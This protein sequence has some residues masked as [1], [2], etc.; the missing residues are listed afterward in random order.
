MKAM[1]RRPAAICVLVAISV[2]SCLLGMGGCPRPT[3]QPTGNYVGDA[4]CAQCHQNIHTNW[5]ATLHAHAIEALESVGQENNPGCQP[6]HTTG[7]GQPGG[8]VDLAS[9][10]Q[11]VGVQCEDCHGPAGQHVANVEDV[12][13]R[14]VVSIAGDVCGNCHGIDTYPQFLQWRQS[15]H[16]V[17]TDVPAEDFAAGQLLSI[18]GPCHSGDYRFEAF[19]EGNKNVPPT[20]LQ[21]VP[22]DQQNAV[23]CVICHDP[24]AR[25]GNAVNPDDDRDF[26]LRYP[27]AASPDPTNVIAVITNPSQYNLCGQ[28]HHSRGDTWKATERSPHHSLQ[29]NMYIGDMPMPV[30]QEGTPLVENTR[31]VHRFVPAQCATCHMFREPSVSEFAPPI[32]GH[33]FVVNLDACS[34]ATGC[35][36]SPAGADAD[37]AALQSE[38][39]SRLDNIAA[40]LGPISTW[41]YSAE[42]GPPASA[43]AGIPDTIKQVRFLYFYVLN[44]G[45]LGVHNPAYTRAILTRAETLLGIGR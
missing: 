25:T 17:V 7:F 12:S 34:S 11:F 10:P 14:P 35:H 42:G 38:V 27:E 23:T 22:R 24:H 19:I 21:G 1:I 16:A 8:F 33:T 20:L 41:G 28:C 4:P 9:T 3:P 44:D 31:S 26:Q 36:P 18:C 5:S 45:S 37:R 2:V 30:G 13:L 40:A 43:Q 39:Q 29:A 15:A 6:C 32:A